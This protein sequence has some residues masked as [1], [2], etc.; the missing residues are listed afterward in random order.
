[1]LLSGNMGKKMKAANK[2]ACAFAVI[3]GSDE[4]GRGAVSVRRMADG[5]QTEIQHDEL[6]AWLRGQL[7]ETKGDAARKGS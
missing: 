6:V 1:M 7:A 3:A 4:L 2:L 5:E